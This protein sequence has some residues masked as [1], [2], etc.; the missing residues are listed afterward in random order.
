MNRKAESFALRRRILE[1][2]YNAGMG[3]IGG[4]FSVCDILC[5]VYEHMGM[6]PQ[7]FE[8]PEHDRFVL[9]KGH[10]AETLYN[11][12]AD[13]G[14]FPHSLLKE[15]CRYESELF[16]HPSNHVPGVEMC[17]GSLG[18]GLPVAVGMA[19]AAKMDNAE[20]RAYTVMGDGELAEGSV[21]EA[22]MLA[23]HNKL[24]NL[25]AVIDRNGLQISGTTEDVLGHE[26][27]AER[28]RAF[29]W[30]V[31]YADGHDYNALEA[32][33]KKANEQKDAPT[34]IIANTIKGYGVSFMEDKAAWHHKI[35]TREEYEAAIAEL[36]GKELAAL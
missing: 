22:A 7:R 8:Q 24:G 6:T 21:W 10:T 1:T 3:H 13:R 35:P 25:T 23:S 29:G 19:L 12:L 26:N 15:Y 4:D 28:W 5:A 33:L 2:V 11:I 14:F 31:L 18:H 20:W 34:V 9:S 36:S 30:H 17:S 27:L 16:G 32:A